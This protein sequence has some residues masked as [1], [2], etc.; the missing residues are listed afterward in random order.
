MD[1]VFPKEV[2]EAVENDSR[3]VKV[4]FYPEGFV[5]NSYKYPCPRVRVV[6]TM[7]E[8]LHRHGVVKNWLAA[9]LYKRTQETYDAKRSNGIGPNWTALSVKGGR[10][11]SG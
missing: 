2:M 8:I 11:A 5:A 6:Y 9:G 7:D 10:L 3:I 1:G 4:L